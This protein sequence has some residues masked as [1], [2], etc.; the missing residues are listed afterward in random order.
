MPKVFDLHK[1]IKLTTPSSLLDAG[2]YRLHTVTSIL[3]NF[4]FEPQLFVN[5]KFE[6]EEKHTPHYCGTFEGKFKILHH[7]DINVNT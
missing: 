1:K 6:M 2:L 7:I 5:P 3:K 4:D